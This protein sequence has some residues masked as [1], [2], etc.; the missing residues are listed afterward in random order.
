MKRLLLLFI[1]TAGAVPVALAQDT[2]QPVM[3]V[4]DLQ[5]VI[6]SASRSA[7]KRS[8][9]PIAIS[10][11]TAKTLQDAKPNRLDQVLNK[12]SGVFMVSLAN[13]QHQMSI[14]QPMTT[15][16][17]F[18][19]LEDGMPI[20]TTGLYNHN[21]LLEMNMAAAKQIE[22]IRGPASSLYGAEAIGGAVNIITLAPPPV[23]SGMISI[24]GNNNGYRRADLQA[25]STFGK[26]GLVV[27]GYYANRHNGPIDYSDFHKTAVTLRTDYKASERTTWSNSISFIDYYS[28]MTGSLDSAAFANKD[29]TT[30]YSFTY[31]KARALRVRSWLTQQWNDRSQTQLSLMFRDNTLKQNPSY[32]ISNN[33]TNPLL[34]NGQE[35]NSSFNSYLAVAQHQQQFKW[36]NSKLIGG[37]SADISPSTYNARYIRIN[38]DAK[39]HYTSFAQT[40]STLSDYATNISNLASYLHYEVE[41]LAGLKVVAALRYDFYHFDFNNHLSP[42]AST[43]APSTQTDF[44]RVT[45]KVGLTYNYKGVGVYANYSQGYVP[46]QVSELFNSV[47]VPYLQP[48]TFFNYEAGGWFSLLQHKL[49][50][51][52]SLYL[53]NGTNEIISVR[54][55][56]GTFQNQNAGK[57]RHRGIEYGITWRP[58]QQWMFRVSGTNA[59]HTFTEYKEKGNDFS[60]NEMSTAPR[61]IANAEF[62]YHPAFI[63]GFRIGLEWQHLGKYWMDNA[64]TR[65]YS[66]FDIVHLRTGYALGRLE[67]WVNALNL[68]N[69]YYA[70][71][72]SKSAYGYSYNLGDPREWN[73]GV[74]CR[75][76]KIN[77]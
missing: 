18:L 47:Q 54:Q 51:D 9:A 8:D 19:Y 68:L 60:N 38:R 52:W 44:N 4:T 58:D 61:F 31:R 42:S 50:A 35:N 45:P 1:I 63:K 13:E 74:A 53:M 23:R 28:D 75:L 14:R 10:T 56:D 22:V 29:Y 30:P 67:L 65:E 71:I 48:Q 77:Y 32:Y 73:V 49:Y 72:A 33:R 37:I 55:D 17:L 20:R 6:V 46:P 62:M 76:G 27:S 12:V 25:G 21:A 57:T 2:T 11:I 15:K 24:Q 34:A 16:S 3:K 26:W 36:L 66:G 7:Q 69:K 5:Q 39:G 43:G 59:R 40:D 41:P 70:T 64:N